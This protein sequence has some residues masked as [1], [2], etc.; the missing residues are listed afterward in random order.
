MTEHAYTLRL[1]VTGHTP[2]SVR[3]IKNLQ[4]ICERELT[5]EYEITVIDVLE[6]PGLAEEERI[7]ATP[8]LIRQLPPPVQRVVGDLSD[9]DKVLLG[10]DLV[11][12]SAPKGKHHDP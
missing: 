9:V 6:S 3:A 1:Y 10:L 7:I 2:R 8:T 11:P 4:A 5:G 12:R